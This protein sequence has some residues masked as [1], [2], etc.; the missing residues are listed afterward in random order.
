MIADLRDPFDE[1]AIAELHEYWNYDINAL[2]A[3]G[4]DGWQNIPAKPRIDLEVEITSK[5]NL[6]VEWFPRDFNMWGVNTGDEPSDFVQWRRSE[7][8]RSG[9]FTRPSNEL[10]FIH[11]VR[12]ATYSIGRDR[13]RWSTAY[14][15]LLL[16]ACQHAVEAL[17]SRLERSF[18]VR[19]TTDIFVEWAEPEEEDTIWSSKPPRMAKFEIADPEQKKNEAELAELENIADWAGIDEPSLSEVIK[20]ARVQHPDWSSLTPYYR[21]QKLLKPLKAAGHAV[22]PKRLERALALIEKHRPI[23]LADFRT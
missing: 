14:D 16:R 10:M 22:T 12:H 8:R 1:E 9:Y 5:D 21:A 2:L 7:S 17:V 3:R 6:K 11:S 18:D 15:P 20:A 4:R 23:K 13:D 19:M